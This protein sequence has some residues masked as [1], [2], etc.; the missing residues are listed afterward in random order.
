MQEASGRLPYNGIG[1]FLKGHFDYSFTYHLY[2]LLD[3]YDY[4][5]YSGDLAYLEKYWPQ[6]K[7]GLA[8]TVALIDSTGMANVDSPNDWLRSG[9]GGHNGEVSFPAL[10]QIPT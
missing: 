2:T 7:R 8:N 3:L 5:T 10:C 6:Y 4:Y 1:Y 9:M